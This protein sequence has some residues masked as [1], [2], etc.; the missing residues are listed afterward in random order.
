MTRKSLYLIGLSGALSFALAACTATGRSHIFDTETEEDESGDSSDS[1]GANAQGST[2]TEG[3]GGG[4]NPSTVGSGSGNGNCTNAPDGDGDGDGWTEIEG[5][6]NNCDPNVNPGSVEAIVTEPDAN[7]NMPEAADEDCDTL[8]DELDD[9]CDSALTLEDPDPMHGAN[10][11]D[12]CQA[13]MP[14]DK[15]WGVLQ[16]AYVRANGQAVGANQ[17]VGIL[18]NFGP[19][20][21][22]QKGKR[23]LTL[24]S[25]YGRRPN[26]VGACNGSSCSTSFNGQ[27]PPGFPQDVP[28]CAGSSDINDDIGLELKLRAPKNATG[29]KFLFKFYSIEFPEYVCTS[30]NDQFIALVNPAPMGS[31]NGNISFD[32]ATN[33]VS[34]NVAYFDVCDPNGISNFASVCGHCK[35]TPNPYCPSG[36][37]ELLANG[38]DGAWSDAGGTSWLQTAAPITGGEEFSIRFAIWDTGDTALDSTVLVDGF[39]WV[40]NGGT[41]NVG[42][43]PVPDPN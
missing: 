40:A 6:C 26:D 17:Q 38:F 5:D 14:G 2:G 4:F 22:V 7:G 33:P 9:E 16:A 24:S 11:I 41:V 42:T 13:A 19:N 1:T 20:V 3:V 29:Y 43:T 32:S 8:V 39:T 30:F 23:L 34:V 21:N 36:T 27:P 35:P 12:I 28:G 10:A 37:A 15:K 18:D 31:I 25:G